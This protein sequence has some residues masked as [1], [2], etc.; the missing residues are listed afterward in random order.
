MRLKGIDMGFKMVTQEV[1]ILDLTYK[2]KLL[3]WMIRKTHQVKVSRLL[4]HLL[5]VADN[6][7]NA[8]D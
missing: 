4:V 5:L 2:V 6:A 8:K 1:G 7:L 3:K